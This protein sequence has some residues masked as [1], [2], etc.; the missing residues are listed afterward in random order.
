MKKLSIIFLLTV[1]SFTSILAQEYQPFPTNN[2]IWTE[3][4]N[5]G[6]GKFDPYQYFALKNGDTII[7]EYSYHKLYYSKDTIFTEN[8]LCGGL[9]EED[10]RIYLYAIDTIPCTY[11]NPIFVGS[12]IILYDFNLQL[13]DTIDFDHFRTRYPGTLRLSKIDSMLI[14]NNYRRVFTFGYPQNDGIIKEAQW[15][16][17]IGSLRGLVGEIGAPVSNDLVSDLICYIQDNEV[18]YHFYRYSECFST[19]TDVVQSPLKSS[20]IKV[21]HNTSNNC[22]QIELDQSDYLKLIITGLNGNE[23]GEFDLIGRESLIINRDDFPHGMYFISV[24]NN[25]GHVQTMKLLIQ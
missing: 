16:E 3:Y 13:G 21:I 18:Y 9:R 4:F 23:V 10:K 15:V 17:G 6:G 5:T 24:Y 25:T 2:A 8:E 20:K 22:I 19:K 7:N 1:L 12:E 11:V 14:G